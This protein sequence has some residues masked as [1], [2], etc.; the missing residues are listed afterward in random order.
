MIAIQSE[1]ANLV[2]ALQDSISDFIHKNWKGDYVSTQVDNENQFFKDNALLYLP[3]KHLERIRDNLEDLQLEI[4]RKNGPLVVD[5]LESSSTDSSTTEKIPPSR[6]KRSKEQVV[7][8]KKTSTW[9]C[10]F[11][12]TTCVP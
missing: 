10:V 5:L 6:K 12:L 7:R 3:V 11:A 1:D 4:G 9:L 8:S 2:A